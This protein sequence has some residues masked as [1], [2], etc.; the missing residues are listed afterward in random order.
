VAVPVASL[1]TFFAKVVFTADSD[2]TVGSKLRDGFEGQFVEDAVAAAVVVALC[3]KGAWIGADALAVAVE[4]EGT[5]RG[6]GRFSC[7]G[8]SDLTKFGC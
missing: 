6:R 3:S 4:R 8:R 5:I 7:D 2:L 1:S